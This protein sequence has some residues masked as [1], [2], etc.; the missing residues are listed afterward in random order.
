MIAQKQVSSNLTTDGG[1]ANEVPPLAEE[2]LLTDVF[3]G[4]KN[5]ISLGC[6][7]REAIYD[8]V[9]CP[10]HVYTQKALS[11]LIGFETIEST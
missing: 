4:S 8:T 3:W 5:Q 9:D 11:G 2:L 7:L 10:T 1:G 6:D